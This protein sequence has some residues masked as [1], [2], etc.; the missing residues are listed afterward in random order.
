M[1]QNDISGL[2]FFNAYT[3]LTFDKEVSPSSP[4]NINVTSVIFADDS[5]IFAGPT[6]II[7]GAREALPCEPK[8]KNK[9]EIF[10]I[11]YGG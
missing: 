8:T 2:S 7:V 6:G 3:G 11:T 10:F 1:K 9:E 4:G 5:V